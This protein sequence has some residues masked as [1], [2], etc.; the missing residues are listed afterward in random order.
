MSKKR[1]VKMLTIALAASLV[2]SSGIPKNVLA[3]S[4]PGFTQVKDVEKV[5]MN[6]SDQQ[7]KALQQIEA[8][9]DFEIAPN[10]NTETDGLVNVIVEF[11]QAPAKVE[12]MEQAAKG[13]RATKR[14]ADAKVE[15]AHSEFKQR[16]NA[17]KDKKS[18]GSQLKEA[19]I[20]KEYRSAIAGVSM[21]VP[22]NEIEGLLASGVVKR[23]WKDELVQLELPNMEKAALK[24]KMLDS[25]PQINVDKLHAEDVTGE[26]IKVAV[27][28][29]GIDYQHPD[30]KDAYKGGYDFIDNDSDPMET[31][32]EDWKSS[33]KPEINPS[34][35]TAYYTEHGTHVSGTI[36]G[37]QKNTVDYAVKGVAP[38]VDLYGY[39]VLGPYGS[40]TSTSVL[41]GIEQ[42][43]ADD[44]DV[45]NLSLGASTN[46]PL[47]PTS[48][49]VNNA[50]LSG[51]VAVVAA[52]NN[53]PDVKTLGAPGA[54][55]LGI[56][57]GAS[58]FAMDI[59]TFET[60]SV[61]GETF[62]DILLL[63]KNFTNDLASLQNQSKE[64]VFAGLGS[65]A[66]FEGK[67]LTGK[68]ALIQ[69]GEFTFVDKMKHAKEAGAEAV[70]IYNNADG[71]IQA[72]LGEGADFI[73]AF[74]MTKADGER[75]KELGDN[76]SLTFGELASMWQE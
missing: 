7:R 15:K 10:I 71:D 76:V 1:S 11:K 34:S 56:T 18:A 43:V 20:T 39:R 47:Y 40:G 26:G 62:E 50:M 12:V 73:P 38:N 5:L 41:S 37:E 36:A 27:L 68:I 29:T 3:N 53:G 4:T 64:V 52:G 67:D 57:V 59:P 14:A 69:R 51:V 66:D 32:Y 58:D 2:G 31:T 16:F 28:D 61:N 72:Y 17:M 48:V 9:P 21:T 70:I 45:M 25:I 6:L 75:L 46:D 74:R 19:K 8:K 44:M 30:L 23:V 24:S 63:G 33:G 35:G 55:A 65:E 49:A 42:A 60:M 54:A 22:G 13:H